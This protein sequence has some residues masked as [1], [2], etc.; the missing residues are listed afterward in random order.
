MA[1]HYDLRQTLAKLLKE[2]KF[3]NND[4]Y[5]NF[6]YAKQDSG[7]KFLYKFCSKIYTHIFTTVD[8]GSSIYGSDV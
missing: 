7:R 5:S 3:F 4:G 8:L 2:V 1:P 6:T